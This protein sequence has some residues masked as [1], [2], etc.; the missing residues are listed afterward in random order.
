MFLASILSSNNSWNFKILLVWVI[1]TNLLFSIFYFNFF[2]V[3]ISVIYFLIPFF[4]FPSGYA[5]LKP[6]NTISHLPLMIRFT[7]YLILGVGVNVLWSYFLSSFTIE[8]VTVFSLLIISSVLIL[9]HKIA[10]NYNLKNIS[11]IQKNHIKKSCE[12]E[13]SYCDKEKFF[14]LFFIF[15]LIFGSSFVFLKFD[16]FNWWPPFGDY[17]NHASYVALQLIEKNI[18]DHSPFFPESKFVYP[19]GFHFFVASNSLLFEVSPPESVLIFSGILI[20]L[21]GPIIFS[22]VYQLTRSIALGS[23]VLLSAFSIAPVFHNL[24]SY[25]WGLFVQGMIPNI[26]GVVLIF[27]AISYALSIKKINFS[28]FLI[29]PLIILISGI[30]YPS[31][32]FYVTTIFL[33]FIVFLKPWEF[34]KFHNPFK[35]NF[36]NKFSLYCFIF[37]FISIIGLTSKE[38]LEHLKFVVFANSLQL[39]DLSVI[40][41]GTERYMLG[42]FFTISIILGIISSIFL[43]FYS[44]HKFFGSIVLTFI[45]FQLLSPHIDLLSSFIAP[46]RYGMIL[47][48]LSWIIVALLIIFEIERIKNKSNNP[49]KNKILTSKRSF[50]L[51]QNK[52]KNFLIGIFG[53]TTI[54]LLIPSIPLSHQFYTQFGTTTSYMPNYLPGMQWVI[55]NASHDDLIFT[56]VDE[57]IGVSPRTFNWI[58]SIDYVRNVNSEFITSYNP[59][60]DQ[61]MNKALTNY[62][63][64]GFLHKTLVE[65]DIKYMITTSNE[66]RF[67]QFTTYPFLQLEYRDEFSTV[68]STIPISFNQE[69]WIEK[70]LNLIPKIFE[71]RKNLSEIFVIIEQ[72]ESVDKNSVIKAKNLLNKH[73]DLVF[74][75]AKILAYSQDYES[76]LSNLDSILFL[77]KNRV[78]AYLLR[79]DIMNH[80]IQKSDESYTPFLNL[81]KDKTISDEEFYTILLEEAKHSQENNDFKHSLMLYQKLIGYD[82]FIAEYRMGYAIALYSLQDFENSKNEFEFVLRLEPNNNIA[83]YYL[84]E[85]EK[86]TNL[87]MK[88]FEN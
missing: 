62:K 66:Q 36:E 57:D 88:V 39:S 6:T 10:K 9:I 19:L 60:L 59:A 29:L 21:I 2:T 34:L 87:E 47:L 32:V 40:Y 44:K 48:T 79:I 11:N 33:L 68:Y 37:Y 31:S 72:I 81:E 85:I 51:L 69:K 18:M 35:N 20:S 53:A 80:I 16:E 22:L 83:K 38:L 30:L 73:L 28:S 52:K 45:L 27:F 42:E 41:S 24:D 61:I 74:I 54:L 1:F 46:A 56:F 67:D 3:P 4:S 63:N 7:L 13:F 25:Y 86:Y 70:N 15:L 8:P 50:N 14:T 26:G 65:N 82:K 84:S 77:D 12:N 64:D 58:H 75:E 55:D 78:D 23:I 17:E 5:I 71:S 76:A 43:L 49:P